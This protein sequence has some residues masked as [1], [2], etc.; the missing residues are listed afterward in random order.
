[1][2]VRQDR[3][4]QFLFDLAQNPQTLLQPGPAKRLQRRPVGLVVGGLEDVRKS[5]ICCDLC[6]FL[7]H[8]PRVRFAF[9]HAR[10]G[11]QKQWISSAEAQRAKRNFTCRTHKGC[12]KCCKPL[13][14]RS[15]RWVCND[16]RSEEH[17]SELQ[18][19]AYLVC[20]LLLEKKKKK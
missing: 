17:T 5:R 2:Y 10:P 9:Y 6:D 18:S 15:R 1:M 20:R 14:L 12:R 19:L 7:R 13:R 8:H 16:L 3:Q 11:D 4:L